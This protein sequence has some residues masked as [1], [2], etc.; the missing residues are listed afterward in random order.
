MHVIAPDSNRSATA[1]SIT[2][3]SPLWVEEVRLR[4]RRDRLRDRRH[5][6]R[7]RALR[8]PRPDRR[9]PGPDRLRD[10]PRLQPRRRHHLL[11]DRRRG[12]GGHRARHPGDRDLAAVDRPGDGLSRS[13]AASTSR[14]RRG[15][16]PSW[17][18]SWPTSRC[19]PAT[20]LNVNCPAGE[21]KGIEVT[22]LGK[23][24]YNDELK[25]VEEDGEAGAAT[26]STASSPP[27]RTSRAPTWP[28]SRAGASRSRRCTSTSPIAAA[29]TGCATGTSR[30]CSRLADGRAGEPPRSPAQAGG[31]AAPRDRAPRPRYYVL[32]D[33]EIGGRRV[34]R[35]AR[36][37]AGARG[38]AP[39]AAHPRLADPAGRRRAAREVRAGSPPGADALA[40]QR[41]QRGGDARLG[42]AD[43]QPAARSST[44]APSE[45]G[46][47][48]EPKIDGL[49]ISLTYEDGEFVRGATRGDGR[50]GEDVTH[51]LR[52]I[53][54]IPLRIDDA[55]R[56][57]RGARRDLLPAPRRSRS[58]TSSAPRPASP[59]SPIPATPPPARS[60]SSTPR[61]PPS[62]RS[63]SGATGSAPRRGSTSRPTRDELE[64]LREHGFKVNAEVA[65]AR[66]GGRGRRALPVVGGA[67]RGARLRDRRRGRQGQRARRCGASSASSAASRA[68]RSHGSSRRS[69]RRRSS[70]RSS[71]TSGAPGA[72][73]R[74]RCS[75]R[76]TSAAS[77][78]RPRPSTTRRTWPA[79]TC[80][81]ATRWS[82]P[83]PAT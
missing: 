68:G 70:T 29:S 17:S 65:R 59:P 58:S 69:P 38:G 44:S 79:R 12:A 48:S 36:R 57:G 77:P 41:P 35:A 16:G 78:S 23:R 53:R 83:A 2:T 11:R 26:R 14:S 73:F 5:A 13:V 55:T 82:S 24:L 75:S 66:D 10:Q 28:R 4:R 34:R 47:V 31:R 50:I 45:F 18:R 61:S 72:W 43:P 60:A 19:P 76:S 9:T 37:A 20:L 6:G 30:R 64:W 15:S 81:R 42:E 21:P 25:L 51:N 1:R 74:S 40:R 56:A 39:R 32:D 22:R 3:R 80:A 27:S 52:T 8:R 49:A 54:A 7:L 46:F 67:P 62:A 63:R 33:P 71:G